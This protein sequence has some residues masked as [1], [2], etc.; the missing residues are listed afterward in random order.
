VN[1]V[2]R[3]LDQSA[4][5]GRLNNVFKVGDYWSKDNQDA[6]SPMP[7]WKSQY[8]PSWGDFWQFD[9]SYLRLKTA[10]ISYTLN[11][12]WIKKAGI[13]ALR[14]YI[15]GNNLTFWSKMPDDR[16]SNALG[17]TGQGSQGAYPTVR[18][19]NFGLNLSL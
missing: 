17:G 18:R 5:G 12:V 14:F 7:R 19:V 1:N 16:E 13:Q 8:G 9:G 6:R 10:E 11:P 2:S 4:F 3:Q 15:N